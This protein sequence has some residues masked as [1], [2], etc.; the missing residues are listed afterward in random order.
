MVAPAIG[1]AAFA[2][3]DGGSSRTLELQPAPRV[4]AASVIKPLLAWVAATSTDVAQDDAEWEVLARPAVTISD[5]S[6]TA[7]LWTRH[8]EEGL[9]AS[10]NVRTG[11]AWDVDGDGEHPA[12]RIMVTAGELAR[13]YAAL[14]S[15][16]TDFGI[17]L[18]Q[19]MREVPPEQT[20]GVRRVACDTLPIEEGAV[21]VKCG[22]FGRER[23]HAI[24]LVETGGRAI[25]AAVTTSCSTDEASRAAVQHAIGNDTKL[26]AAHDA[27]A[28][29]DI[30]SAVR[31]ALLVAREL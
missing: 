31:R 4:R 15:D 22:W 17:Q 28:G 18:R 13:A 26:A 30:R 19:W 1:I 12:L 6:A 16:R 7:A 2:V 11:L 23:A 14:A 8:G 5:N 25:G 10:L 3:S 9:L 24:V 20:F 21:G 27:L 29:D